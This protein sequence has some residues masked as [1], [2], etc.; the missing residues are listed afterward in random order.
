MSWQQEEQGHRIHH[1]KFQPPTNEPPP[2]LNDD[3]IQDCC[4]LKGRQRIVRRVEIAVVTSSYNKY[5]EASARNTP[6]PNNTD[7]RTRNENSLDSPD[8]L[9]ENPYIDLLELAL[10]LCASCWKLQYHESRLGRQSSFG[11]VQDPSC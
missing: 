4:F 3:R 10:G 1:S 7:I 8:V 6:G 9:L 11:F 5:A 2:S